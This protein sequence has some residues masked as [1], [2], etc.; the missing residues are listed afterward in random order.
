MCV[1]TDRQ[2]ANGLG[3][4][5]VAPGSFFGADREPVNPF[6]HYAVSVF[7]SSTTSSPCTQEV[8]P[9]SSESLAVLPDM[10]LAGIERK[11]H[12]IEF[13][14]DQ[15][16]DAMYTRSFGRSLFAGA[17]RRLHSCLSSS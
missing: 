17:P 10:S 6:A 11:Q 14:A 2:K 9:R 16:D 12:A 3:M 4:Q 15:A 7:S 8:P 13:A 1:L 5:N